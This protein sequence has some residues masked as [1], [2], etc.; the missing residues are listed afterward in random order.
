MPPGNPATVPLVFL[1]ESAVCAY[2]YEGLKCGHRN[3]KAR[4]INKKSTM[5]TNS[6][7][8]LME[9]CDGVHFLPDH[10]PVWTVASCLFLLSYSEISVSSISLDLSI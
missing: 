10:K 7:N 1:R 9:K 6:L 2:R 5:P 8:K 3:T 4:L